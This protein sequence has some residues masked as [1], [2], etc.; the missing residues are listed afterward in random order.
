[1]WL[2][3]IFQVK[4][5]FIWYQKVTHLVEWFFRDAIFQ[6]LA[7]HLGFLC[8][9]LNFISIFQK[10]ITNDEEIK[11]HSGYKINPPKNW[12][13]SLEILGHKKNMFSKYSL[14]YES[15][16]IGNI[17]FLKLHVTLKPVMWNTFFLGWKQSRQ[18]FKAVQSVCV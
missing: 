1:M 12:G 16:K 6:A 9:Y 5:Y 10:F 15:V 8:Q 14:R 4:S 18:G 11:L 13:S 3:P 7:I 17:W 2:K